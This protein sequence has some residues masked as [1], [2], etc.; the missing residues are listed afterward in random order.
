MPASVTDGTPSTTTR[1]P[2]PEPF[3]P[4]GRGR[5]AA[6]LQGGG[7]LLEEGRRAARQP[8]STQAIDGAV[9]A[10]MPAFLTAA[11]PVARRL[12]EA[13]AARFGH[14]AQPR[15]RAVG[16]RG[17]GHEHQLG[18]KR[19]AL[20]APQRAPY[21]RP[22]VGAAEHHCR[23]WAAPATFRAWLRLCHRPPFDRRTRSSAA[24]KGEVRRQ[25]Q[26][27]RRS[28]N[29]SMTRFTA[30]SAPR[31]RHT[32][33]SCV[34]RTRGELRRQVLGGGQ[35]RVTL[36]ARLVRGGL[37]VRRSL[38]HGRGRRLQRRAS[39]RCPAGHHGR[40]T[41]PGSRPDTRRAPGRGSAL[42]RCTSSR[43]RR[44][45]SG[46]RCERYDAACLATSRR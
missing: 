29:S 19:L 1:E 38:P 10:L 21:A 35:H 6:V 42:S 4:R 13:V 44:T 22:R 11:G 7:R 17:I 43:S 28:R 45:S 34:R 20:H 12:H 31:Y 37:P 46:A 24:R 27:L 3:D 2:G 41:A 9:E 14:G 36:H 32:A 26:D 18:G 39:A 5:G 8:A 23:R 40:S 30:A 33:S 15:A 25:L 16:C